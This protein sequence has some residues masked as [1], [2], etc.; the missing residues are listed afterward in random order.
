M[1]YSIEQV[2]E[3]IR[4]MRDILEISIEEMAQCVGVPLEEYVACEQ[5]K[6]DYSFTFLYICAERFGIDL[7]ELLTGEMPKLNH[8][9]IVRKGYG[10]SVKRRNGLI[11]NHLA[12]LFKDKIAEPFLVTCEYHEEEQDAEIEASTH[13][14]QEM[15]FILEGQLKVRFDDHIEILNEG[16]CIYYDSSHKH[17]MIATGGKKCVFIAIVMENKKINNSLG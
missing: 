14:G 16:D 17:G 11:Y 3:R 7:A 4:G 10:L 2:A 12:Y 13:E 6:K 9:T 15:D 8:Y 1:E 5:G